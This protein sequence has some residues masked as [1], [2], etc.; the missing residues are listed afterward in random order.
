MNMQR[1]SSFVNTYCFLKYLLLTQEGIAHNKC[2]NCG[3]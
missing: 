1:V 3:S 2:L